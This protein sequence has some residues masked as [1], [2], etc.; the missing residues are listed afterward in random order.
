[1]ATKNVEAIVMSR[2]DFGEADRLLTA[3]T[4]SEGKIKIVA[5]G[6]RKI[7]SK[8]ASAIEP[9]SIGKYFVAEGKSFYIL[10]GAECESQNLK[11]S[12]DI[13]LYK[14]V[15]YIF[16]ILEMVTTEGQKDE[17]IF[18]LTKELLSSIYKE[19]ESKRQIAIRYFEYKI[20]EYSGFKPEY[21]KC[22]SCRE[23]LQPQK[24]FIGNF[25]GVYC[26]KCKKSGQKI[27]LD[28][29][30]LLRVFAEGN[31]LQVL[32]IKEIE[33]YNEDLKK[34]ILPQLYDILPRKP[35]SQLL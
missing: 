31:L 32:S 21:A 16:E 30:K 20:L 7:K 5:R 10:A 24:F 26:Q 25:E 2:R 19:S 3:L 28:T 6:A 8:L 23:K 18:F 27:S 12:N 22:I 17:K 35:H 1:M 14:D 11:I 9:F 15:S 29:I 13:E 34:V 4:R 33:S